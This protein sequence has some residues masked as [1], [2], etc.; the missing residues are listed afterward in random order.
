V[1][2]IVYLIYS[3]VQVY[4]SVINPHDYD[5]VLKQWDYAI[6]GVNPTEWISVIASPI[7][8]EY[9]QICYYLFFWIPIVLGIELHKRKD[10]ARFDEF[11]RM[12]MF[13]FYLSYICYLAMPAI[14]PRFSVHEF[15]SIATEL[16][17]LF[18]TDSIRNFVNQGGG[19][20]D[21]TIAAAIQ[22]NRDCMPSGHTWI[23]LV[24]MILAFKYKSK[25]K[26]PLLVIGS[27]LIFAT[28]YLRYHYV[29]DVLAGSL[30]AVFSVWVEPKIRNLFIKL[31]FKNA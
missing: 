26:Y 20:T 11:V 12:V 13:S 17:G 3:Q 9:L 31:G 6:F 23:T 30:L 29:V 18:F 22:V 24:T 10:S 8:T 7:L 27:S 25:F 15:N 19:I 1:I 16:P 2:P 14:G 28:I 4:I 5:E 21:P